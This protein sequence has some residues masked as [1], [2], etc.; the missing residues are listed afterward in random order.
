MTLIDA[1]RRFRVPE[2]DVHDRL[3]KAREEADIT[4]QR[5]AELLGCSRRTIVRYETSGTVVPRSVVLAYHV[6][7]ETDLDWLENGTV[8]AGQG[9]DGDGGG[10][11]H[12]LGLEP[13]THWLIDNVTEL[14]AA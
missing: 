9:P 4:Q 1:R 13:R 11:V 10:V 8:P 3:S 7:T 14:R 5:M 2:F 6:A 12:P